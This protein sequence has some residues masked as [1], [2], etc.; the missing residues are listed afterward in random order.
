MYY[1]PRLTAALFALLL[2]PAA[3]TAGSDPAAV[4]WQQGELVSRKTVPVGH[5][6]FRYKYVYRLHGADARYVVAANQPLKLDLLVPIKFAAVRHHLLIQDAD[7]KERKLSMVA[8]SK[9]SVGQW[10]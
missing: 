2:A 4:R 1:M 5:T 8:R 10:K 9:T 7:G 6:A 3:L